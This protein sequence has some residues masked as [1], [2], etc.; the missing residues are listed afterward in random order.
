MA[1]ILLYA[2]G[3]ADAARVDLMTAAADGLLMKRLQTDDSMLEA[4]SRFYAIML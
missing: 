4:I 1:E 3:S 2:R